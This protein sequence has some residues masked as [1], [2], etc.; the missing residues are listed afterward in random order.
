MADSAALSHR[1]RAGIVAPDR[2]QCGISDYTRGLNSALLQL[3]GVE[4]VRLEA[5]PEASEA[6]SPMAALAEYPTRKQLF[7]ELG[8][9]ASAP[10]ADIVHVQHEFS[11]LGGAAPHKCQAVALYS[12]IS[13]PIVLTVHE[14][15]QETGSALKRGALHHANR[16]NL[17]NPAIKR[18]IV[19]TSDDKARL[20]GLGVAADRIHIIPVPVPQASHGEA[21]DVEEA[22]RNLGIEGKRVVTIFGFI[23]RKKAHA[24]AV[25]A[26]KYLPEDVVLLIAGGQHPQDFTD[27]VP[28]VRQRIVELGLQ[29]R[30]LITGF[31]PDDAVANVMAV[32]RVA[33]APFHVCS[34]S[35]SVAHLIASGVPVVASDITPFAEIERDTPGALTL[36]PV[37]EPRALAEVLTRLLESETVRNTAIEAGYLY[38]RKHSPVAAAAATVEVYRLAMAA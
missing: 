29:E 23:S 5:Y 20:Q 37:G 33:A 30:V 15:L 24:D 22:A 16:V 35:A 34:G 26:M 7:R 2:A 31:L 36:F 12:G 19:H 1:I 32:S 14:V 9:R 10:P 13:V 3:P 17:T 11:L 6:A 27:Y 25:E 38:A 4:I 8:K 28:G 21:T 18:W